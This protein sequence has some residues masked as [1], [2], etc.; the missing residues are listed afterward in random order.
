MRDGSRDLRDS[1]LRSRAAA[2]RASVRS[3]ISMG[4][5]DLDT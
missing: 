4:I 2:E 1:F 5:L 3:A